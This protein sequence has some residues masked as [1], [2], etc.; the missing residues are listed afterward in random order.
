MNLIIVFMLLIVNLQVFDGLPQ[1]PQ[2]M[3]ENGLSET[4]CNV[5]NAIHS[6]PPHTATD[7]II[8]NPQVL[9]ED[10]QHFFRVIAE[11]CFE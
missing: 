10:I 3:I 9:V 7:D 1:M 4:L 6:L 8:D 11:R 2:V 5:M